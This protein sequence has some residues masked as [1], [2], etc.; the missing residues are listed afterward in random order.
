VQLFG[1]YDT[2]NRIGAFTFAI[3]GV[4]SHDIADYMA[5]ENICVRA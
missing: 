5:E 3:E 1:S 4:H 2:Q